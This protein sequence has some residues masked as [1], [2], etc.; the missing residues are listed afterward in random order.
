MHARAENGKW[1][2]ESSTGCTGHNTKAKSYLLWQAQ[3]I[4]KAYKSYD[5]LSPTPALSMC[6]QK[7]KTKKQKKERKATWKC[8][9]ERKIHKNLYLNIANMF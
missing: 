4:I 1:E 9:Q 3:W 5:T 2:I 8:A 7:K 6:L